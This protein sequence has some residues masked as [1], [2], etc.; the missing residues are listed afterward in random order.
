MGRIL[1]F[2]GAGYVF[3][4]SAM[5]P[6][7]AA[8]AQCRGGGSG[9]QMS[10]G[11]AGS[12]AMASGMTTAGT[13]ATLFTGPGSYAYDMRM[14]QLMVQRIMQQR[15][16]LAMQQQQARQERLAATRYRAEKARAEKIASRD[17]TRAVL[18]AA[19][20]QTPVRASGLAMQTAR[21]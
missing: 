8:Q 16:M 18:A 21:H 17:R 9:G 14:S 10:A 1:L 20:R 19:N 13:G 2:L 12:L 15:Q 5:F 6:E 7:G 11:G 3:L 4:G